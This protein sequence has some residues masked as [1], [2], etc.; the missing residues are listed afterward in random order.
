MTDNR[1]K[2]QLLAPLLIDWTLLRHQKNCLVSMANDE[3]RLTAEID[4]LDGVVSLLDSIQD[5]AVKSGHATERVV[6]GD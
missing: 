1:L 6:F 5:M 4:V 3:E 2:E